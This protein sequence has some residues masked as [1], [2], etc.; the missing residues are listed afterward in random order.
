[1]GGSS[2]LLPS[3]SKKT[4]I[5]AVVA[6]YPKKQPTV[7]S[8]VESQPSGI[9]LVMLGG[10]RTVNFNRFRLEFP[11]CEL[12]LPAL[13]GL[14]SI[15]QDL[16]LAFLVERVDK[17][18]SLVSEHDVVIFGQNIAFSVDNLGFRIEIS[19]GDSDKNSVS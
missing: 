8:C 11:E 17:P 15:D 5:T 16:V 14:K 19:C 6:I 13:F 7:L 9:S 10:K 12:V 2:I 1:M 4:D 18:G 3:G